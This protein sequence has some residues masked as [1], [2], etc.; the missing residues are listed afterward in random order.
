VLR[1]ED[2]TIQLKAALT[3]VLY[4]QVCKSTLFRQG[5]PESRLHGCV[6]ITIHGT[7]YRL[8]GRYDGLFKCVYNDEYIATGTV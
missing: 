7:G 5:L 6:K 3:T 1:R 8:P 4:A 2:F